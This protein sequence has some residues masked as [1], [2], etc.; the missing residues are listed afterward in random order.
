MPTSLTLNPSC[1]SGQVSAGNL[2]VNRSQP[3]PVVPFQTQGVR[4]VVLNSPVIHGANA[5]A[6]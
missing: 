2:F 1:A 4:G 3:S 5:A 6:E